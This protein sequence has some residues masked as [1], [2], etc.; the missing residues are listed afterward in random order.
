MAAKEE[1]VDKRPAIN[2]S[3]LGKIPAGKMV[4][5]VARWQ[6]PGLLWRHSHLWPKQVQKAAL[7]SDK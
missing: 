4:V 7:V 3:S 6:S 2:R 5:A 1:K